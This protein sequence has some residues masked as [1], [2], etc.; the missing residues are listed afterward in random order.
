MLDSSITSW[1]W[2]TPIMQVIVGHPRSLYL[3]GNLHCRIALTCSV[4]NAFVGTFVFLITVTK[5]F[6]NLHRKGFAGWRPRME[7]LF[8]LV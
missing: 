8:G 4:M 1:I 7:C 3:R 6:K 2:I 5:S